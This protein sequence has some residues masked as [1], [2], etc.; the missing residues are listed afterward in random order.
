M[1]KKFEYI[2]LTPDVKESVYK[3]IG[4]EFDDY[5]QRFEKEAAIMTKL[6]EFGWEY[7][8]KM[9]YEVSGQSRTCSLFKREIPERVQ[10]RKPEQ[11]VER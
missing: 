8:E 10:E 7:C 1:A 5:N 6:G 3:A 9:T 2:Y 11:S 4:K